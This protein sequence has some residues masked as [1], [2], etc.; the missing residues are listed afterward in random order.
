MPSR[1][2]R[3]ANYIVYRSLSSKLAEAASLLPV[4]LARRGRKVDAADV[5]AD[6]D[7][8]ESEVLEEV[9]AEVQ[10]RI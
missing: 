8:E 9:D 6:E 4:Y 1:Q 7:N 5:D 10:K 3:S 2:A